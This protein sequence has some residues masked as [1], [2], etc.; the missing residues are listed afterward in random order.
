MYTLMKQPILIIGGGLMG[1]TTLYELAARGHEAVLF[2]A[3]DALGLGA[4]FANGGV[5]HPSLPDP[6]NNP[7]IGGPLLRSLFSPTAAMKLHWRQLPSLAGWGLSFL[8][9]SAPAKHWHASRANYHLATYATQQTIA[10]SQKLNLS[11]NNR[12][13][14]MMKIYRTA[15]ALEKAT[16]FAE[17]LAAEGLAFEPLTPS[18]MVARD[19]QL[20]DAAAQAVGALHFTGD[21][22]GD[23]R[24]FLLALA[25]QAKAKGARIRTSSKVL[26]LMQQNGKVTGLR[27][28][29]PQGDET[30]DGQVVLTAGHCVDQLTRPLGLRLPI[31]PAKGYSMTL[32]ASALGDDMPVYPIVDDARHISITPL[33]NRL[34]VLGTA[35]FA[36][37]DTRLDAKRIDTLKRFLAD[38]YPQLAA[39]LDLAAADLWAGL[40]PMSADGKP[41][42]GASRRDGLW[43]NCGHGHLGWTMAVGSAKLLVHH[44]DSALGQPPTEL[45]K[46][47]DAGDF[48]ASR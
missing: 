41:F 37:A 3:Q 20:A 19:R 46:T 21:Y 24:G 45:P 10:L 17:K 43:L 5:L 15:A 28:R 13:T 44:I 32:D 48:S 4:S 36:G 29:T 23:A 12:P 25:E 34:R 18:Q 39:K 16:S 42:I 7:G 14:G 33:G 2:E 35:E 22:L 6:W 30:V 8:R 31:R 38:F 40:R 47:L 1:V 27:V 26:H 11:F 9:H